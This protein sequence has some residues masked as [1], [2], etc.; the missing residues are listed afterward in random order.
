M[1]CDL[2]TPTRQKWLKSSIR[3]SASALAIFLTTPLASPTQAQTF[4]Q[5]VAAACNAS[6]ANNNACQGVPGASAGS[7]TALTNES[8]PVPER[9]IEKLIGPW[10]LYFAGDYE[11]FHKSV[12]T[13]EPG[14][15]NNIWYAAV[16]ADYAL[17]NVLLLGGAVRYVHDDGDFRGGGH[18]DTDSYGFLLHANYVP[19]PGWFL[20]THAGYMRKNYTIK[21]A[22]SVNSVNTGVVVLDT[23][24]GK[25]DGNEYRVGVNGGYDFSFQ[26]I[27][28]GPR[29]GLNYKRN[30]IDDYRERRSQPIN[31]TNLALMYD[32]QHK[33]SLT[34]AIG[35][36]GSVA[37]STGF[38]V[39]VPQTT[40]EYVHEFQDPQRRIK[41][42]LAG[43][44]SV[45]KFAFQNDPP[46]RNYFNLGAGVA[47][48]LARGIAPFINYRALV[49]YNEQSSHRVT[50]GL[51]IEF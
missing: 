19:G 36:Y 16:G 17:S 27:T 22:T 33:N 6:N 20:D 43:D 12:T 30:D 10:N 8:S 24:T 47:L 13:F 7:T 42:R 48:Q 18:F 40:L 23:L 32:R 2:I 51:R 39:L 31:V 35:L 46:D 21:R 3:L 37:I 41:F 9:K 45:G 1:S 11:R 49:G 50:A 15:N 44:P 34:S 38:G 25:P 26:N 4:D 28:V 29:V 14:Y 5:A